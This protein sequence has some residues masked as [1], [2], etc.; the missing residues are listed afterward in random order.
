M[1]LPQWTVA[2]GAELATFQERTNVD[3]AL[4]LDST[5]GITITHIAGTIPPGL[6]IENYNLKGVP[7]E[8]GKTT[9]FEFVVRASNDEGIA[10]RTLRVRIEGEDAPRWITPAGDLAIST[11]LRNKYWIDTE[12]TNWGIFATGDTSV[13]TAQTITIYKGIPS[14]DTGENGDFAF[15]TDVQ[16]FWYK[17]N[18]RWYRVNE[19]QMKGAL[20]T[21]TVLKVDA[22]TPNANLTDFWFNLNKTTNGLNLRFRF[23]DESGNS[24]VWKN[25]D[26]TVSKTAPIDPINDQLWVQVF[27]NTFDFIIKIYD[28]LEKNWEVLNV[29][30]D[31]TPP[32]RVNQAYFVLDSSVVDFQLQAIDSDLAAGEKL[33]FFIGDDDGEL[34]PGLSLSEDGRITGIVDPILALDIDAEPGYDS[35]TYDNNPLDFGNIADDDGFDSYFYDTTFYG[36]STPT[37]APKKL[38]R[39]YNFRVTVEDDVSSVKREFRMYVVGDDFLRADN[40]IMKS[41]TGL[42]TAD[43]TYLRKPIWLTPGNLGFKRADNYVTLF[44]D[45]FDPNSLLGTISYSIMPFNDDGTPSVIPPGL[46]LDG[47]T[48]ELAGIIPYQP[49]VTKEYRF[50]I[51]AL[52]QES[53][54]NDI[55]EINTSIIEDTLSGKSNIKIRKLP[56][57]RDDGISDLDSLLGQT[58]NIDNN[59]YDVE[60]VNDMNEDYDVLELSR[61]LEP[62][63]K[64]S[65]PLEIY[66]DAI[67]GDGFLYVKELSQADLDFYKNKTLNYSSTESY[68]LVDDYLTTTLWKEYVE[69]EIQSDDSSGDL[70][71]NYTLAGI[72]P[73]PG[74]TFREA[75]ERY[76]LTFD[77]TTSEYRIITFS[78]R[79]INFEILSTDKTRTR[80]KFVSVISSDDSSVVN[81]TRSDPFYKV[82]LSA[83]LTRSISKN[84]QITFGALAQTLIVQRISTTNIEVVSTQKTFTINVLGDVSSEINWITGNDLGNILANRISTLKIEATT[85]LEGSSLRY[86]L[87]GGKLPFGLTLKRDGELVGKANQYSNS[88]GLGLTTIDSRTT[89]FDGSTTTIDR[90]YRFKVLARDRFGYSASVR[91]FT[92]VV[93]DVDSKVYSNVFMQPFPNITQK[94]AFESFIND[95]RVFTP[96]YIYRPFDENFGVQKNLRTLAYAGIEAKSISYFVAA[97]T[98]NHKKKQFRFGELKTAIAKKPGTND[99][100]YEV[101]YVEIVD[102]M[103]PNVG[104]TNFTVRSK[105]GE[106]LKVNDVKLET[107]DDVTAVD[108]GADV[109][110]ITPRDGEI[111]RIPTSQGTISITTRE[112]VVEVPAQAQLEIVAQDGTIIVFRSTGTTAANDTATNRLRPKYDVI[113]IDNNSI[114]VSQ[115]ANV[116]RYISNIGNMRKRI[117]EIGANER[118]YL[119]LWMR[120]SQT[121]TGQELDYVT[122]MPLCFCKP[123]TGELVKENIINNGFEFNQIKYEIDRY[124]VSN[125]ANNENEQFVV[126]GNY[127]YN[128]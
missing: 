92:L 22:T 21:D 31:N 10:D 86:D 103:Q 60:S 46:K 98:K 48:G 25:V 87:I 42:F 50:T 96:E 49:A 55:V 75:F 53:D 7:F 28:S 34:P 117:E 99:V 32:D 112:G 66:R 63:Y 23:Y 51:E 85:T 119:P 90:K 118:E 26:Y 19:T 11:T 16:Q 128:V 37:R 41:G 17:T 59:M 29:I 107:K 83:N 78:D 39:Y 58:I 105:T 15:V 123:G 81:T 68:K 113:T 74:E 127:K 62:T 30:F 73:V 20:G 111:I 3:I 121:T 12:N 57:T 35:G 69:Y 44:L 89:T 38:N 120:S 101:V 9:E 104:N 70:Q 5:E 100:V 94:T 126:F 71:F 40:T 56:T 91:E 33:R 61:P 52:R 122:A 115:N 97:A 18:D 79:Y 13:F 27:D 47:L 124:I 2:T 64:A 109:Y 77:V 24:P 80:N 67:N 88:Q 110:T 4:P 76:L 65:K 36:F 45:V 84:T 106:A 43:S 93:N 54:S 95:Y 8:V 6:R 82:P 125:T 1:A 72:E 102:P 108:E 114:L 14:R 116:L